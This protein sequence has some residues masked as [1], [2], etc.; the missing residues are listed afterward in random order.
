MGRAFTGCVLLGVFVLAL[1]ARSSNSI[2]NESQRVLSLENAWNQAEL[3]H[4]TRALDL[5]LADTFQYTDSTGEYM[6]KG[7]WLEHVRQRV[8][9]Y[10]QLSN[11]AMAVQLYGSA[12]VVTG[13]YHEKLRVKG[14]L[15]A[16]SGRFTDTW[17][18]EAGQWRCVASQATLLNH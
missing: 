5:L 12:A 14:K 6:N 3:K 7:V 11:S 18:Q 9:D 13:L 15:V 2:G 1:F 8:D 17:I 10:E 16:E 4:D